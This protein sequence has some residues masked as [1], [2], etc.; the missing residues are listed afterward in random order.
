MP[1]MYGICHRGASF[2][3]DVPLVEFIY[4]VRTHMPGELLLAT[5]VFVVV[6]V[7]HILSAD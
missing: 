5:Q 1:E 6:L 7:L 4:L 2:F 3:E